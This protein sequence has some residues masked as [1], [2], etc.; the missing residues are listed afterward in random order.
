MPNSDLFVEIFEEL[1][2]FSEKKTNENSVNS[3]F[4]YLE[5]SYGVLSSSLTKLLEVFDIIIEKMYPSKDSFYRHT[6]M[7][8]Y[9]KITDLLDI[10][11]ML[12]YPPHILLLN[13]HIQLIRNFINSLES[14]EKGRKIEKNNNIMGKD[15][16]F[17][18][19][20]RF[21]NNKALNY[22]TMN[23]TQISKNNSTS[24]FSHVKSVF[25][26]RAKKQNQE[27][28]N[29]FIEKST[30]FG[31]CIKALK[32]IFEKITKLSPSSLEKFYRERYLDNGMLFGIGKSNVLQ[33]L[34]KNNK[35]NETKTLSSFLREKS[36]SEEINI[37]VL[38]RPVQ[39]GKTICTGIKF[40]NYM[41]SQMGSY[42][43]DSDKDLY[44]YLNASGSTNEQK[45]I[46]IDSPLKDISTGDYLYF[47]NSDTR[48]KLSNNINDDEKLLIN[49]R[50]RKK[51]NS[52]FAPN[53]VKADT[54]SY[55]SFSTRKNKPNSSQSRPIERSN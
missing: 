14:K 47:F 2:A 38:S 45:Q 48:K 32:I 35:W 13:V 27:S 23:L 41:R 37:Y 7:I 12:Y 6:M 42:R 9:K 44:L 19:S 1:I 17:R 46:S 55:F 54:P 22:A 31:P 36:E 28:I 52:I 20:S 8:D 26:E 51:R 24:I 43:E 11:Q 30:V 49:E 4:K 40:G 29:R 50:I 33:E 15:L 3:S 16:I 25:N 34:K 5:E 21:L 10:C 39:S 53:G 18:R